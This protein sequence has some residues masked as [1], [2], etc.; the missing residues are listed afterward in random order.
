MLWITVRE[1]KESMNKS[2]L[3]L[4]LNNISIR[5]TVYSNV[6]INVSPV[7]FLEAIN[8]CTIQ[9]DWYPSWEMNEL[10]KKQCTQLY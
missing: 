7:L 1:H 2:W 10:K 8:K 3:I 4:I 9:N 6:C 5:D